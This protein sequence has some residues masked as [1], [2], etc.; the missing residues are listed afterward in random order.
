MQVSSQYYPTNDKKSPQSITDLLV[1]AQKFQ[2][3]CMSPVSTYTY[4]RIT[5]QKDPMQV[6]G[7]MV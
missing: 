7:A 3:A 1:I 6:E 2:H 5:D 4:Y